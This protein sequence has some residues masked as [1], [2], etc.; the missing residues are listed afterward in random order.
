MPF[1]ADPINYT[2]G[3]TFELATDW[4]GAHFS[5]TRA[6]NSLGGVVSALGPNWQHTFDR[7]ITLSADGK[8]ASV[9]RADGKTL[10]FSNTVAGWVTSSDIKDV[11]TP[12]MAGGGQLTGWTYQS[13]IDGSI[14][15]YNSAGKLTQLKQM[16][17][18]LVNLTYDDAGKLLTRITDNWGNA[19]ILARGPNA[20]IASLTDGAGNITRYA[21][22]SND[23]LALVTYP[24]GKSIRY[25][26]ENATYTHLLTGL[27]DEN[28]ERYAS[29]SYDG[30]GRA[31]SNVQAG[32]VGN[33]TLDYTS[34]T[35]TSVLDPLKATRTYNFTTINGL[36]LPTGTSQ[37][38]GS[39]CAAAS[40]AI[41]Y[42]DQANIAA[43]TDFNGV[44]TTYQ[45]D[46]S[47]N[48]ETQRIEAAGT[49]QA[50]TISTQWHASLALPLK[51][52]SPKKLETYAYDGQGKL[53]TYT[54]QATEDAT[55]G[56]G[57]NVTAIGEAR[58]WSY[59]FNR[60]GQVLTMTDP[61]GAKTRYGYD[62]KGNLTQVVNA[63]EQVTTLDQYDANG[64]LG[65]LTDAAGIVTRYRYDPRGRL[66]ETSRYASAKPDAVT[67]TSYQYDGVGNLNQIVLADGSLLSYRYDAA[68][69][70]TGI[71]DAQGNRIDYQLDN[72]GNRTQIK[73]SDPAGKL[74]RQQ[75]RVYDQLGRLQQ[76]IG[77][78][79]QSYSYQY[80]ANGR[81]TQA[82]D[83]LNRTTINQYDPLGR[84]I[85]QTDPLGGVSQY[86]YDLLDQLSS[87]T[88]PRQLTTRYTTDGLGKR[89]VLASP[90][91]GES[92]YVHDAAGRLT[93]MT[94]ARKVTAHYQYDALGRITTTR[95]PDQTV[96]YVWDD[97]LPGYLSRISD[98]SGTLAYGYDA[99]GRISQLT[100]TLPAAAYA[101]AP[102]LS[103][104]YA[105]NPANQVQRQTLPSGQVLNYQYQH[106]EVSAIAL[107]D[108]PLVSNIVYF[109]LGGVRSYHYN[110]AQVFAR[111]QDADGR[112]S[113]TSSPALNK[114]QH[115]DAADRLLQLRD[116]G[117][118]ARTQEYGYDPLDRLLSQRLGTSNWSYQY[119]ANGNRT[120]AGS[121]GGTLAQTLAA[122][123]NR[124]L[125]MGGK[126]Y[127]Y[128]ED[129]KQS[130]DGRLEDS[131]DGAGRLSKT[132][133]GGASH[134]YL[135]SAH[136]Q[137]R[138]KNDTRYVYDQWGHLLGEYSLQG[139]PRMEYVWLG[140]EV[141]AVLK[142]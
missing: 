115:Y 7:S 71:T 121:N 133:Q 4:Q 99:L 87:A 57:L 76:I 141:V 61:V 75:N 111:S 84:L 110:G 97:K 11:L 119:D 50:R 79:G 28:G 17:G 47:R 59:T 38:G 105:Y 86:G 129:G 16:N 122:D 136:G 6:Y 103:V 81:L 52:A 63:L 36:K 130:S 67:T 69:R 135:Y 124:L 26:Y 55:G 91:S 25:L 15:S 120:Q 113:A 14:E 53:L 43:R 100:H 85:K 92:R 33:Y 98:Q 51:I 74:A 44:K 40:S 118:P 127:R 140:D 139:Q 60:Y 125:Q 19:L 62:D 93:Q 106:G 117:A 80:D 83:A 73:V 131:Y 137:R 27:I 70:L 39:G 3:N 66:L 56:A 88:D 65:R 104:Q 31:V 72:A 116:E 132:I 64:R 46:L 138:V 37:P 8:L 35:S 45:Y 112:I 94:D 96:N 90:D 58:S 23:N 9:L 54:E 82:S 95:Y 107:G 21:Y 2:V 13:S 101:G 10:S 18:Q 29:W 77:M 48:L 126:T 42:D 20:R 142:Y 22:D 108:K 123:S 24:D 1:I 12:Q 128:L 32:G 49:P 134:S 5:F 41:S 78:A 89:S 114:S 102:G 109:P 68:H 30:Q 34:S